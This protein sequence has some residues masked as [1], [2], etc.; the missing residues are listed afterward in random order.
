MPTLL[1]RTARGRLTQVACAGWTGLSLL[2]IATPLA[3]AAEHSPA[4]PRVRASALTFEKDIRPILKANCFDCHGEGETLKGGLDL[5]LK[6]LMV[7]GGKSGA[8]IVPGK[9]GKSHLVELIRQGDMPKREKKLTAKE[10]A[11]IEKWIDAGARTARPEPAE[12]PRGMTIT[13][14]ERRH[15]AFQPIHSPEVP[16]V[17]ANDRGRTSIDAFLLA[18]LKAKGLSFSADADRVTLLRRAALDLTGLPPSPEDVA[19]FVADPS[20]DAYEREI[21]RFLASPQY[22]ERWARHWLD[23]AGYA[24]SD[25]ATTEDTPRAHA[26]KYRDYVIRSFNADKPID[27]FLTE[28]LAGDELIGAA[29]GKPGPAIGDPLALDKLIATGFLRMGP[30]GTGSGAADQNL[31][32]NQVMADTIKI[33]STSLLGL[34]VG[35]AQ[36]HDHRYDPIPQSDYYRIRAVFEPAYDWKNW[37]NPAERLLSL[38]TDADRARATE[39]EAEAKKLVAERAQQQKASIDAVLEKELEKSEA[40]LRDQLREA[41]N[42]AGDKRTEDQKKLLKAH[43]NFDINPGSLY[44]YDQKAADALKAMDAKIAEVRGRRPPEEFVTALTE[45]PGKVPVTYLFHRGDP[46]QPKDAIAPGALSVLASSGQRFD[47]G[48]T[49]SDSTTSGRRLEFARWLTGTNNPLTARVLVNRIWLHHFGRGLVRTPA[50][51]G[52]M[53]EKPTHPELLDWLAGEFTAHGWSL[54]HLHKL[55]LTSTVYRQSSSRLVGA[56]LRR[57]TSKTRSSSSAFGKKDQSLFTSAAPGRFSKA[58]AIDPENVLYWRKPVQRLEAEA[59]RDSILTISG[60]LNPKMFGPPV[61]VRPDAAGQIV[62]G[63]DK[64]EGDN[65]M[66]VEVALNGE[67]F[68]RSVYVQVRRS[69]PLAMLTAFDAPVMEINCELRQSSTVAPQALMLMNSDFILSQS[70]KFADRLRRE[71]TNDVPAQITRAWQ[72]AFARPPSAR[73][74][75][76]SLD[77]LARQIDYLRERD[78]AKVAPVSTKKDSKPAPKIEPDVQALRSLCQ[79]LLGANELLYVD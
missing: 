26:W 41:F 3:I 47:F 17:R 37:R 63:V 43:P 48:R 67:E 18:A 49:N 51:F 68:R 55:I 58:D 29:Q 73:E 39:V 36:C 2:L 72:L 45:V 78:A 61:P 12:V 77:F 62:V 33:V 71:A 42:T 65:K 5:R 27:L 74:R 64:T 54:K 4:E 38:Y 23:A 44:L 60:V 24:D 22:G 75:E 52:R 14:E 34:S 59:L 25:G 31:A 56:D 57:L 66:P 21:D 40:A 76:Q 16:K 46:Q 15:W 13:E 1:R 10:I 11:T 6:R 9:P 20:P 35:C 8:A 50:D 53:G 30:D 28:Q 79:S 19:R 32:R 69:R 70:A 7:A